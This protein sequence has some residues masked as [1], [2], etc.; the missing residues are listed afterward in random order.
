MWCASTSVWIYIVFND[1]LVSPR[2]ACVA[3]L[4]SKGWSRRWYYNTHAHKAPQSKHLESICGCAVL[5]ISSR[6]WSLVFFWVRRSLRA[7]VPIAVIR[8]FSMMWSR[9][10]CTCTSQTSN[11][12]THFEVAAQRTSSTVFVVLW[13]MDASRLFSQCR[14]FTRKYVVHVLC[15]SLWVYW[16][17]LIFLYIFSKRCNSFK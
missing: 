4:G 7:K 17:Y 12:P 6:V 16:N 2:A 14:V 13:R 11:F 10:W 15:D 8:C 1:S 5:I 3:F 9:S